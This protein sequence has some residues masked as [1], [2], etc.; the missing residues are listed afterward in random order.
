MTVEDVTFAYTSGESILSNIN[1]S[2]REGEISVLLGPSGCGKTTL[3]NIMAGFIRPSAGAVSSN[4]KPVRHAG[5]DRTVVFQ[6]SALFDWM[7]VLDNVMAGLHMSAMA[8][9]DKAERARS[10]LELVGLQPFAKAY[11]RQL[12][13]GMRQRTGLARALAP[14]PTVML[15]DE[16]LAALDALTREQL[17]D[18]LREIIAVAGRSAFLI[19][20]DIEEAVLLGDRIHIM[21]PRPGRIATTVVPRLSSG[22]SRVSEAFAQEVIEV[23]KLAMGIFQT[24][25]T[26]SHRKTSH[27]N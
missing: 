1:M 9:Q 12:S 21:T 18:E 26:L 23:R 6:S 8:V 20:H 25:D 22:R 13:G 24:Q 3:L 17:Q 14:N 2:V 7:T 4:G 11:P 19:T 27:K 10:M 16:P 15:L 5:P